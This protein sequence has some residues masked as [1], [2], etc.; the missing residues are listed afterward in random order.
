MEGEAGGGVEGGE[1]GGGEGVGGEEGDADGEEGE[2]DV[3]EVGADLAEDWAVA[4]VAAVVDVHGRLRGGSGGV[5][6]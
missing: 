2:V 3:G 4:G 1:E 5:G 6:G